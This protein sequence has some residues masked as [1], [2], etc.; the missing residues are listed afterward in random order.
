MQKQLIITLALKNVILLC[1]NGIFVYYFVR[2]KNVAQEVF[3]V[4]DS[5]LGKA[6]T[7]GMGAILIYLF[8]SFTVPTIM[9]VPFWARNDYCEITGISENNSGQNSRGLTRT[10][11]ISSG[12]DCIRVSI[13]GESDNISIGDELTIK[14]LPHTHYGYIIEH[15]KTN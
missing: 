11:Q 8:L 6:L 9:D 1:G 15:N 4:Q 5:K 2:Y 13:C 10:V 3:K 12:E 14:Y 7:I